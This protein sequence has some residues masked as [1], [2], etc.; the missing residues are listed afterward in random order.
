MI[1]SGLEFDPIDFYNKDLKNRVRD[2]S[3]KLFEDLTSTSKVDTSLNKKL[4]N[5][6]YALQKKIEESEKHKTIYTVLKV[7]LWIVFAIA[8]I[9]VIVGAFNMFGNGDYSIFSIV[10]LAVGG[11]VAVVSLLV[12]LLVINK[13]S[14][15]NDKKL[16]KLNAKL[17]EAKKKAF[18]NLAPLLDLFN[19][20]QFVDLVNN[21]GSVLTV[22]AELDQYKLFKLRKVYGEP[23]I[24]EDNESIVDIY[25]GNIDKNPYVRVLV[26][27]QDMYDKVYTGS[28][29]VTWTETYTDSKGRLQTRTES[30]T[31]IA[32][33]SAPAPSYATSSYIIYGNGAAPKLTFTR[34]PSGLSMDHDEKDVEKLVE[35]RT[36]KIEDLQ[37]KAIKEGKTFTPLANNKFESLFYALDRNNETEYRLLFTPLAQQNMV[38]VITAKEPYGDDFYFLKKYKMNY[39]FSN[40]AAHSIRFP[41]QTFYTY[42]DYEKI[43]EDFINYMCNEYASLYFAA[44]PLLAVP[45]YQMDE[46]PLFEDKSEKDLIT[47]FE[48]E[49]FVNHMNLDQ[50]RNEE[51]VTDQI[52]KVKKTIDGDEA[53]LYQ[54]TS[55]SFGSI[56]HVINIPCTARNGRVYDVPVVWYEYYPVEKASNVA[57]CKIKE[58]KK[59]GKKSSFNYNI[60][61]YN[62]FGGT[63]LGNDGLDK[64]NE[65][66]FVSKIQNT[67]NLIK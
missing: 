40:H 18:M 16:Q 30:Q 9:F 48:A 56:R 43:K 61:R 5:E 3:T 29:T 32:N 50:F 34:S 6:I 35:K 62:N 44:A 25:S 19:F 1:N 57:I 11:V 12:I 20:K 22:D 26:N 21:L 66:A 60:D 37:D 54:V 49:A 14:K 2:A 64:T 55:H 7:L 33:Y 39:I 59:E 27:R 65:D 31:L 42:F 4:A 63:F 58:E 24:F 36:K 17:S 51:A 13:K 47:E 67:Y 38:E 52:L 8:L 10:S 46:A 45:L 28:R 23:F 53:N 41:Y 15:E